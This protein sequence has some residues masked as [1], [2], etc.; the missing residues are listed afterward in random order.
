MSKAAQ[1]RAAILRAA[2]GFLQERPFRDL[3]VGALMAEAGASRATFYQYFDDLHGL[4]A[5][6]LDEVKGSIVEGAQP[7]LSG[8]GAPG[9]NLRASLAALVSVGEAQGFI[10][11]AVAEAA[12]Q[13]ARLEAVWEAF[14]G[15]FD[16]VVAARIEVDQDAGLIASFDPFPVARALN[17]MDA[18]YL[19]AAFGSA[20]KE[21]PASVLAAIERI[22]LSTLYPEAVPGTAAGSSKE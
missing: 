20:E 17:R 3:T 8:Q 6:L 2:R 5:T 9:E 15:A 16:E 1:T 10:L 21:A 4:M 7:W 13:D 11:R 19:I 22:W 18:A 12:T 14:L